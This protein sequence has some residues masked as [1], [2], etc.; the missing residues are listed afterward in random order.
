MTMEEIQEVRHNKE[1]GTL[2]P[3]CMELYLTDSEFVKVFNV[4]KEAFSKFPKWRQTTL[5]KQHG[6]F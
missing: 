4:S 6:L 1:Y 2:R 5:K 3:D